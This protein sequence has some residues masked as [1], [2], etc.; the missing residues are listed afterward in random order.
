MGIPSWY[1]TKPPR[2]TQSGHPSVDK[3]MSTVYGYGHRYG[4]NGK[5]CAGFVTRTE[6]IL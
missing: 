3:K 5:F 4:R 1:S 6:G 2:P